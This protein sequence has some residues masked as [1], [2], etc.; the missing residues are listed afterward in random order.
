MVENDLEEFP[1]IAQIPGAMLR[2]VDLAYLVLVAYLTTI[3]NTVKTRVLLP[4]GIV[5]TSK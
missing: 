4:K 2:K 1:S 5:G 3:N